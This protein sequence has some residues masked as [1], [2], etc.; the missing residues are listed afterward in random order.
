MDRLQ[1]IFHW[2]RHGRLQ[3]INVYRLPVKGCAPNVVCAPSEIKA[4]TC[5]FI[6]AGNCHVLLY[7]VSHTGIRD[8]SKRDAVDWGPNPGGCACHSP[9]LFS[10][11]SS[12][13]SLVYSMARGRK[14]RNSRFTSFRRA[15]CR[16]HWP[17]PATHCRASRRGPA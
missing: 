3:V 14:T 1:K 11:L 4:H 9:M 8:E 17:A 10:L 2:M 6:P 13:P 16:E 12:P 5:H 7:L 15:S